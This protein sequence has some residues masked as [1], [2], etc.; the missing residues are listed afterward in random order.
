LKD[1]KTNK[2]ALE[3]KICPVKKEFTLLVENEH[4]KTISPLPPKYSPEDLYGKYRRQVK[5]KDFVEKGLL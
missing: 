4:G 2:M 3:I 1:L 5:R